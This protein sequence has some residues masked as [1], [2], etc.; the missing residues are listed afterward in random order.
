MFV[1]RNQTIAAAFAAAGIEHL[2][3]NAQDLEEMAN[4][5]T[6]LDTNDQAD[7]EWQIVDLPKMK[8]SRIPRALRRAGCRPASFA[9]F[10][11][12][13]KETLTAEMDKEGVYSVGTRINGNINP[14]SIEIPCLDCVDLGSPGDPKIVRSLTWLG[15]KNPY[16]SKAALKVL[17]IKNR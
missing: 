16:T 7:V 15:V 5:V 4:M 3:Y 10:L 2:E 17:G 11:A 12:F 6:D 13:A 8:F 14:K 1:D 9:E